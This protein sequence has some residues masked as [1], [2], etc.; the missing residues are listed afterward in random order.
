MKKNFRILDVKEISDFGHCSF[1]WRKKIDAD[2]TDNASLYHNSS[3]YRKL[4][5]TRIFS[6]ILGIIFIF[7]GIYKLFF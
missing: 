7:L 1:L 4:K 3:P 5:F 6:F 2:R